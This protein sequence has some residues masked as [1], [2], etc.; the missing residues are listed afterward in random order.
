MLGYILSITPSPV[1]RAFRK[2]MRGRYL[3]VLCYHRVLDTDG[4]FPFDSDLVSASTAQFREQLRYISRNYNV[5]NFRSLARY[6][7]KNNGRFPDNPLLITFDDG[8]I[9]NYTV[10]Y[11]MLREFGLPA[12]IFVTAGFIGGKRL[13]WW[14]RIAYIV[15]KT[16]R[17]S[18]SLDRPVEIS[19]DIESF[20]DRQECA[21]RVI[22]LAKTIPEDAK[23]ELIGEL[24]RQLNV[25]PPDG[26][27]DYVMSWEQ[28]REMNEQGI[29]IGAHSVNHPIF[30]NVDDRRLGEEVAYSR[31]LIEEKVGAE[32]ITFGSPGRGIMDPERR[33]RF[34]SRLREEI[35]RTGYQFSTMYRWGLVYE[36]D[37]DRY[38]IERIGIETHDSP[39]LF[40]AKLMYPELIT[41]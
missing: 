24:S 12:T 16:A 22:K 14:D 2:L 32:V 13:F 10:A 33:K 23:E 36:N 28:L 17:K 7:R 40:R 37:F 18:I 8:Y 34:N 11:P 30:S 19:L 27:A 29:E 41:Y 21:R 3:T 4:E 9:D 35:R 20:D 6:L 5:L 38:G 39:A 1:A 26:E 15:K 31:K 25:T